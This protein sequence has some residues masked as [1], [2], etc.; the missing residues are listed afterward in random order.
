MIF[1]NQFRYIE[2]I[3]KIEERYFVAVY[4]QI[5]PSKAHQYRIYNDE[6]GSDTL[7]T[8]KKLANSKIKENVHSIIDLHSCKRLLL[9]DITTNIKIEIEYI[10]F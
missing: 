2:K 5:G 3:Y 7:E 4:N 9:Q 1:K 8:A 10:W 6:I